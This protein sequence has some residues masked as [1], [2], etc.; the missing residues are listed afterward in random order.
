MKNNSNIFFLEELTLSTYQNPFYTCIYIIEGHCTI[1]VAG[2]QLTLHEH[3]NFMINENHQFTLLAFSDDFEY[4]GLGCTFEYYNDFSKSFNKIEL[5]SS[6]AASIKF[7]RWFYGFL[8][9]DKVEIQEMF[10]NLK[11]LENLDNEVY[12]QYLLRLKYDEIN[13]L[14]FC[15]YQ[16]IIN[17]RSMDID[18]AKYFEENIQTATLSNYAKSVYM[19]DSAVASHIKKNHGT[20]FIHLKHQFQLSLASNLLLTTDLNIDNIIQ[21]VGIKNKSFFYKLFYEKFNCS[22]KN[23]RKLLK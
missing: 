13:L 11:K 8:D 17:V 15:H 5:T 10:R 16:A 3:T 23:Y 22:P 4:V 18:I 21:Q 2:E 19:S 9:I 1:E 6:I 12:C 20:T 14:T 7:K